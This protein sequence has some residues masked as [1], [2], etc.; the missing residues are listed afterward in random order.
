MQKRL[1]IYLASCIKNNSLD[2]FKESHGQ[3]LVYGPSDPASVLPS[4]GRELTWAVW[5]LHACA[6]RCIGTVAVT[7]WGGPAWVRHPQVHPECDDHWTFALEELRANERIWGHSIKV[8]TW[9]G[10]SVGMDFRDKVMLSSQR[11]RNSCKGL[12]LPLGKPLSP[13][14]TEAPRLLCF[15]SFSL[16]PISFSSQTSH[17]SGHFSLSS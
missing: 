5:L 3:G 15:A 7:Q 12:H 10:G 16:S 9:H 6:Q 2:E 13:K 11:M 17:T 8:C 14:V 4:G 1:I